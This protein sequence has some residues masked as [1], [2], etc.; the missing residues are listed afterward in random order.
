MDKRKLPVWALVLMDLAA[1][2]I[3]VGLVLLVLYVI[4]Q[5]TKVE[6][7]EEQAVTQF[8]LPSEG[9]GVDLGITPASQNDWSHADTLSIAADQEEIQQFLAVK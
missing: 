1:A 7:T 9:S 4:P 3:C 8:A 2:A 5:G 6:Q